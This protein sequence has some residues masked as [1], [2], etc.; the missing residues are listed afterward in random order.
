MPGSL[1][2]YDAQTRNELVYYLPQGWDPVVEGDIDGDRSEALDIETQEVRFGSVQACRRLARTIFLGGAP[3]TADQTV[4]GIDAERVLLGVLQ[5]GQQASVYKDALRR[6]SDHLHYLN[7]ANNRFWFDVR[8]NFRREMEDRK[9]RFTSKEHLVPEIQTRL[10]AMLY[11]T[12]FAGIH[13]FSPSNDVPDDWKMHLVVLAPTTPFNRSPKPPSNDAALA[14][15]NQRGDQPRL[16]RN[17][18]LFLAADAETTARLDDMVCS[19]KAWESIVTVISEGHLNLDQLQ[20]RQATKNKE[21]ASEAVN[22]TIREAYKWLLAPTEEVEGKTVLPM[23]WEHFALNTGSPHFTKE[24]ER[25]MTEHELLIERWSPIH[26]DKLLRAWFW[27][28]GLRD[29]EALDVWQKTCQY[30]YMPRLKDSNVFRD[31][32]GEGSSSQDFYGLAMGRRDDKYL[33][34]TFG[35][36]AMVHLDSNLIIEPGITAEYEAARKAVEA[37]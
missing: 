32:L 19:F 28:D 12:T 18:L 15:L 20:A 26:L 35:E 11:A 1:P 6:L 16:K 21:G 8:P 3:T 22:R 7:T 36:R 31:T 33:G 27:K 25:V 37:S 5:P 24:I 29:V 10:R 17:R 23:R 4:R 14:I 30:L 13:V 9:R 34:F 2:L